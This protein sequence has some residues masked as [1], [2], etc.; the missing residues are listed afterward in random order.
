MIKEKNVFG[1]FVFLDIFQELYGIFQIEINFDVNVCG[2]FIVFVWIRV[3]KMR[4]N[5]NYY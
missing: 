4:K 2:I 3:Q 1:K 5:Y